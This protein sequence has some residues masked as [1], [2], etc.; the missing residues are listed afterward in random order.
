M[1]GGGEQETPPAAGSRRD[2]GPP[3]AVHAGPSLVN[4]RPG[5]ATQ[6]VALGLVAIAAI[7]RRRRPR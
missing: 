2:T 3:P 4:H 6:G 7:T 1:L 5:A